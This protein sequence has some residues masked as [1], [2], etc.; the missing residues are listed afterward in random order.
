MKKTR[1]RSLSRFRRAAVTFVRMDRR[2]D[3]ARSG[4]MYLRRPEI[5]DLV[6]ESLWKGVA[7]RHY[8]LESFVVMPNHVHV[9]LFP[10]VSP[11]HL[12]K[13]LKGATAREA[14]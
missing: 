2:L 8:E 1:N 11:S 13:S 6:V 3:L 7:L 14:T 5:A 9:L 10:L 4:P 12:L